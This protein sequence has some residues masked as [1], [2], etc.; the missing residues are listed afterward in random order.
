MG[1]NSAPV[2]MLECS[3]GHHWQSTAADTS[4]VRCPVCSTATRV[5]PAVRRAAAGPEPARTPRPL[6]GYGRGH[7]GWPDFTRKG[8]AGVTPTRESRAVAVTTATRPNPPA[9]AP[10]PAP[11]ARLP[12]LTPAERAAALAALSGTDEDDDED[13]ADLDD[14]DEDDD[15]GDDE[16]DDGLS[17]TRALV[18]QFRQI[19][20]PQKRPATAAVPEVSPDPPASLSGR[21]AA[22]IARP[23][24]TA[25]PARPPSTAPGP[26][27]GAARGVTALGFQL[28]PRNRIAPGACPVVIG[29]RECPRIADAGISWPEIPQLSGP[30]AICATCAHEVAQRAASEG[31]E[32]PTIHHR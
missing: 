19:F 10:R 3:D 24:G 21:L 14:E 6:N 32:Y 31:M 22:R 17:S 7:D 11:A 8:A 25:R 23:T 5:G 18:E 29:G 26:A 13:T 2:R 15:Q 27:A 1:T 4:I 30:V 20:Q 16:D 9:P 28:L 12:S